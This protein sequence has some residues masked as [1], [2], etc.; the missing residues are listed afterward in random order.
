MF[1]S[2]TFLGQKYGYRPFP[3]KIL[4]TEFELILEAVSEAKDKELLVH[5]F[6]RDENS[7]PP[8]YVL[9]PIT[10]HLPHFNDNNG[11]EKRRNA[12]KEWWK[13]FETMQ[14]ILRQAAT[15]K[16]KKTD[17]AKYFISGSAIARL[18]IKIFSSCLTSIFNPLVLNVYF[19]LANAMRFYCSR[20]KLP[21]TEG[22]SLYR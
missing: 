17:V 10:V 12:R 4:A 2:K 11:E 22:L 8:V 3:A 1:F 14:D 16:L 9:Q 21:R 5:W 6:Y 18:A 19:C 13:Q 20:E 7:V 15:E